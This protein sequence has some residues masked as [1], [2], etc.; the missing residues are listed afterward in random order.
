MKR[1]KPRLVPVVFGLLVVVL[2]CSLLVIFFRSPYTHANLATGYDKGYDRTRRT[3]VGTPVP[4]VRLGLAGN[5]ASTGDRV[6]L[7]RLLFYAADCASCHGSR[8]QGGT[9]APSIAGFDLQTVTQAVRKGP[10]A[11]PA[12]SDQ[13]LSADQLA[14]IEAYLQSVRKAA[15]PA[16]SK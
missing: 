11:M 3:M 14:D 15:T 9:F 8:G 1:A 6:V 2:G 13:T 16:P 5:A 12:F 10:G 4:F 7:G